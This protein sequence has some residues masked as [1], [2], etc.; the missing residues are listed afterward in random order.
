METVVCDA[1]GGGGG[2]GVV[3][4]VVVLFKS[5][6]FPLASITVFFIKCVP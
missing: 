2:G 6:N 3:A 1:G 4:A 5:Y